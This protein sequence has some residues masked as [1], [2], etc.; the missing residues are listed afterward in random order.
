MTV[1]ARTYELTQ[2]GEQ[3][4][5]TVIPLGVGIGGLG[6]RY[7]VTLGDE[8]VEVEANRPTEDVLSLLVD[9]MSFEAGLVGDDEGWQVEIMGTRHDVGVIDPRRKALKMSD[10]AGG[11]V[12]KSQMP[13]RIVRILV[14]VGATVAKGEPLLVVEAMKMENELRAPRDGVIKYIAV[15]PDDLVETGAL[16][17]ELE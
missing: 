4:L 3:A 10:D 5:V 6:R 1:D 16:L 9:G 13:G 11:G 7:R 14:E 2:A 17:V 8:V 15:A 12:I